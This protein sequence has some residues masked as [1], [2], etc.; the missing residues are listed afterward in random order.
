[1]ELRP[2]L[3]SLALATGAL[4]PRQLRL[5]GAALAEIDRLQHRQT[6]I[7][8]AW[9]LLPV[10]IASNRWHAAMALE[11]ALKRIQGVGMR[12]ILNGHRQPSP[13]ESALLEMLAAGGP[14]C[15]EKLYRELRELTA[16]GQ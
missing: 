2:Q 8:A 3:E 15:R 11:T 12:R 16:P 13:L 9:R 5:V 10:E 7:L 14:T 6:A 1:M 4:S